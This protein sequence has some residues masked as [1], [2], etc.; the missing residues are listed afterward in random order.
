M[1][2]KTAAQIRQRS[3]GLG[4]CQEEEQER[5][6]DKCKAKE[7]A[8]RRQE[9]NRSRETNNKMQWKT[10]LVEGWYSTHAAAGPVIIIV[11]KKSGINRL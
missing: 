1:A 7:K 2:S 6:W 3:V 10:K 9:V 4:W 5:R 8:E 11:I